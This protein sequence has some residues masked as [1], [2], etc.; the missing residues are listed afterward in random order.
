[1]RHVAG[2][3]ALVWEGREAWGWNGHGRTERGEEV[4]LGYIPHKQE[5]CPP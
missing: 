2:E 5:N 4:G 1:M 3:G